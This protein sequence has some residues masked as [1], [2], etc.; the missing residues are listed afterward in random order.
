MAPKS[1]RA[2]WTAKLAGGNELPTGKAK[3]APSVASGARFRGRLLGIDPSLR[4]MG[5]AVIDVLGADKFR[6]IESQTLKLKKSITMGECL[7]EISRTV[8]DTIAPYELTHA[9]IEETIY[10]QN[11]RTAQIMGVARG[12]AIGVASMQGLKIHE[13]SPLS[14][15]KSVTGFGRASKEQMSKQTQA[16]LALKGPLPFDEADAVAVAMCHDLTWRYA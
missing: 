10:V 11:F 4:G 1:S 15:K 12:A 3:A 14:S 5:L 16:L 13:Y 8:M 6:L 7:G 2:L 9:A